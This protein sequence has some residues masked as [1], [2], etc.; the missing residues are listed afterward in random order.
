M[1]D[2]VAGQ[3]HSLL[4]L[5]KD[6]LESIDQWGEADL[7]CSS[8]FSMEFCGKVLEMMAARDGWSNNKQFT[9]WGLK[10]KERVRDSDSLEGISDQD[11]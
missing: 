5:Q 1:I 6:L 2:R 11:D 3:V 10:I 8:I 4:S 9:V 7:K